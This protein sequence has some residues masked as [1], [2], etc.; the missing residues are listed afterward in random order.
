[1]DMENN[2]P[3][4][5]PSMNISQPPQSEPPPFIPPSR[6][7]AF[8]AAPQPPRRGRGWMVFSIIL[9]VLLLLSL[10]INFVHIVTGAFKVTQGSYGTS[11]GPRLDEVVVRESKSDN[12]IAVVDVTG[13]ISGDG[14]EQGMNMVGLIKS[15]LKRAK[16]DSDVKA[17]ILRVD[18]P[19][20]EVLA[21]DEIATAIRKFQ[22]DSKKPVVVSMGS[23]AASGGYYV[24][25]PCEWIVANEL[26]ITGSIGVIMEG[27]NYRKLMDKVG[28]APEVYKS[29]ANKDMMSPFREPEEISLQEKQMVQSMINET[30]SKF[31]DVV[32]DGRKDAFSR[33]EGK[34][35][36][37]KSNWTDFADGRILSGKEAMD[38]GLVDELGDFDAAV[39]R[40]KGLAHI[41]G[42][43]TLVQYQAPLELFN[44]F[45]MLGQTDAKSVKLDL[46]VDLPKLRTGCMYYLLPSYIH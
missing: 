13:V 25:T 41:T 4:Q 30:F 8:S 21:A 3:P 26:T 15:Q 31:K 35:K 32:N 28:I 12:K 40:T 46:G 23:L 6:P 38:L 11:S 14:G 9:L 7:A 33:N 5:D 37:L 22:K 45:R 18:S 29:G 39:D 43:A 24:S 44:L 36:A 17:V 1:M 34:G 10:G 2:P 27:F 42:D 19:G 16:E 20:G